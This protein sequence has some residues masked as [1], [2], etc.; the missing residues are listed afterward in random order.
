MNIFFKKAWRNSFIT[1][2]AKR[3][4]LNGG[5][6]KWTETAGIVLVPHH[7]TNKTVKQSLPRL[8]GR[9]NS[10]HFHLSFNVCS[11]M[12]RKIN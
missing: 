11:S 9:L 6:R 2:I 12:L 5:K 7:V 3:S 10:I 1:V 4:D 8:G